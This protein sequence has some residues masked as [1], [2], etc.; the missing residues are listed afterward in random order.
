MKS[1]LVLFSKNTVLA[2]VQGVNS[3][4]RAYK[5]MCKLAFIV[6]FTSCSNSHTILCILIF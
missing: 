4:L 2:R 3:T 1:F 6:Y 5:C